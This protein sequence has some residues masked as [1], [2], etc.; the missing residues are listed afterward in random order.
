MTTEIIKAI[1]TA[2]RD[3]AASC[4]FIRDTWN[5]DE[6]YENL[7][8]EYTKDIKG[9]FAAENAKLLAERAEYAASAG[10]YKD[11]VDDL[12]VALSGHAK[13]VYVVIES[14]DLMTEGVP[15]V[16][17]WDAEV[18]TKCSHKRQHKDEDGIMHYSWVQEVKVVAHE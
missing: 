9:I 13:S 7:V 6:K 16:A 8:D 12:R 11:M 1:E 14:D 17:F 4:D 10:V 3:F 15:I 18:A 2:L 5:E